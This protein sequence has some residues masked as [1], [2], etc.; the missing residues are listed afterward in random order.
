MK[1]NRVIGAV[2]SFAPCCGG[3]A[4]AVAHHPNLA[5]A[6]RL[7]AQ[8]DQEITAAQTAN[9]FDMEGHALKARDLMKQA[10]EELKLANPGYE[11]AEQPVAPTKNMS[12]ARHP[13]LVSAQRLMRQAD[14]KILAA[15]TGHEF[16]TEGHAR[17]A[18]NLMKQA[19]Q[20]LKLAN[21]AANTK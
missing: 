6:Q 12:G 19:D 9:E 20:E 14:Q 13:N 18:R 10:D 3:T 5:S 21:E 11:A 7:M 15:Q 16:D 1:R 17:K 4:L 2:L 8:A